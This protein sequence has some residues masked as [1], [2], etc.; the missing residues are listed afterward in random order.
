MAVK[1]LTEIKGD[2]PNFIWL[3]LAYSKSRSKTKTNKKNKRSMT[4][5]FYTDK[6][7]E[8]TWEQIK[9]ALES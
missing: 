7:M 3:T 6:D 1:F 8:T 5:G 4:R 2:L 9:T